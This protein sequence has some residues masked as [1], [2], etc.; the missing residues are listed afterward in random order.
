MSGRLGTGLAFRNNV[1]WRGGAGCVAALGVCG[2]AGMAPET[3]RMGWKRTLGM[4]PSDVAQ[5]ALPLASADV[6]LLALFWQA[7]WIVKAV[8]LGLLACSVWVW[9]IIT[10]AW[11]I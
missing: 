1:A 3:A 11:P 5:S 2:F 4:N 8:M 9:A 10:R 7:H 6:S